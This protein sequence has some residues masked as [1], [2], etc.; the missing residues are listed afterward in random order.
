MMIARVRDPGSLQQGFTHA[1]A[2]QQQGRRRQ[3]DAG[4][5]DQHASIL[6]QPR[7]AAACLIR[8]RMA[9][10]AASS[11]HGLFDTVNIDAA[12]ARAFGAE[13]GA[14]ILPR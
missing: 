9:S 6:R 14:T 7:Y 10:N 3:S 12:K 4:I 1:I 13:V 2:A 11:S 8:T 5:V